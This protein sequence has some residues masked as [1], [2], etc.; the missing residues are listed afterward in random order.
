MQ[1][2]IIRMN[3]EQIYQHF[4]TDRLPGVVQARIASM[5]K[6]LSEHPETERISSVIRQVLKSLEQD[7]AEKTAILCSWLCLNMPGIEVL[8]C[9]DRDGEVEVKVI[10]H[11]DE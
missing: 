6:L 4:P 3:G 8:D 1:D 2:L 7:D 11:Q 5:D 10:R 9:I